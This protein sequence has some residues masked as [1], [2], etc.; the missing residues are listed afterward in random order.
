MGRPTDEFDYLVL[1]W[2]GG[3]SEFWS[4]DRVREACSSLGKAMLAGQS[5]WGLGVFRDFGCYLDGEL[6]AGAAGRGP[7]VMLLQPGPQ[8]FLVGL[9]RQPVTG[10][11]WTRSPGAVWRPRNGATA[12]RLETVFEQRVLSPERILDFLKDDENARLLAAPFVLSLPA[13]AR[14]SLKEVAAGQKKLRPEVAHPRVQSIA[15]P[16]RVQLKSVGSTRVGRLEASAAVGRGILSDEDPGV[17]QWSLYD[18]DRRFPSDDIYVSAVNASDV[19]AELADAIRRVYGDFLKEEQPLLLGAALNSGLDL[20]NYAASE[21]VA[22][23]AVGIRYGRDVLGS[24]A[25]FGAPLTFI[26]AVIESRSGVL[27]GFRGYFDLTPT[28]SNPDTQAEFGARRLQIGRA[29]DFKLPVLI[30][31]IV[32]TPKV[33]VWDVKSKVLIND[34]DHPGS[35][36]VLPIS[37]D[38]AVGVGLEAGMEMSSRR[39]VGRLWSSRDYS[40]VGG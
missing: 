23:L 5:L 9:Y 7:W 20:E 15:P 28:A 18:T 10:V 36:Y 31:R 30:D 26:G 3:E 1:S 33:G 2:A 38:R 22:P 29:F 13:V 19:R 17:W 25:E 4:I 24:E 12:P 6:V 11:T 39:I 40:R 34:P 21:V 35:Q 37:I 8:E 14:I 27:K 16:S 32:L